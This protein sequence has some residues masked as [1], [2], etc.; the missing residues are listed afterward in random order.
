MRSKHTAWSEEEIHRLKKLVA[1][2]ASALRASVV[3]QRSLKM[4]KR[5]ARDVGTPFSSEAELRAKRR[6]IVLNSGDSHA[7]SSGN[8]SGGW[9]D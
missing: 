9:D 7:I 4:I 1:L 2:G 5:K 6:G 3:L 8:P